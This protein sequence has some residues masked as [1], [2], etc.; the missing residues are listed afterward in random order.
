MWTVLV[1]YVLVYFSCKTWFD[2]QPKPLRHDRRG[3]NHRGTA[4]NDYLILLGGPFAALVLSKG[5]VNTQVNGGTLQK[6][7]ANDGSASLT[8]ILTNDNGDP[9]LVDTQY[10]LFNVVA[11]AYV[12]IGLASKHQLPAIPSLLLALTGTSAATYT[13]NKAVQENAP[14][15]NAVTPS[16][17]KPGDTVVITGTNLIPAGSVGLPRVTIGGQ[18][19][20]VR[21]DASA[22][23]VTA[24]VPPG[25]A[26]GTSS[27]VL[28]TSGNVSSDPQQILIGADKPVILVIDPP[29]TARGQNISIK[30]SG[31]LSGLDV[32]T[33]FAEFTPGGGAAA[34]VR[35]EAQ[36]VNRLPSGLEQAVV[37]VPGAGLLGA[38]D[39]DVAVVTQRGTAS[40]PLRITVT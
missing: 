28:T 3:R 4:W 19:A 24:V 35:R 31:F 39:V 33:V 7:V 11:F 8:Q 2:H 36:L 14:S 5:I 38:G 22:T 37:A 25:L 10:F 6:T 12:V 17:V 34:R 20:T 27:L 16:T 9:D 29:A 40:D 21:D 15:V 1:A 26:A 18:L 23:R 32:T 13:I 30:G